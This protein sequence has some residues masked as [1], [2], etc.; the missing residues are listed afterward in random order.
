MSNC[1][2]FCFKFVRVNI[3][4]HTTHIRQLK[5][6][7]MHILG[8]CKT[9]ICGWLSLQILWTRFRDILFNISA[10]KFTGFKKVLGSDYFFFAFYVQKVTIAWLDLRMIIVYRCLLGI[11]YF[12][13]SCIRRS[14][15][16]YLQEEDFSLD[17]WITKP[18]EPRRK[19]IAEWRSLFWRR[20]TPL[21]G[22]TKMSV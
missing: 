21:D 11:N 20:W 8:H 17:H 4:Y 6:Q 2:S 7:Y 15:Y 1:N 3:V 13:F 22:A 5:K 10:D 14:I 19:L 18:T 16:M 9:I 12:H